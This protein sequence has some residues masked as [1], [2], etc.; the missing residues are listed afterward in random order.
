PPWTCSRSG[1]GGFGKLSSR[2]WPNTTSELGKPIH[3]KGAVM[4]TGTSPGWHS[5]G[6]EE[7]KRSW[8]WFLALGIVLVLLG[9]I[10]LSWSVLTTLVSV[11]VFGWLL[12]LGGV[13][14]VVH[15]FLRRRWGGF[16][17]ELFAG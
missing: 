8:V 1:R 3:Q 10:A 14:S 13:L 12:L 16:F 6:A 15:A 11:V 9:L 7:L 2:P 5:I 4:S 17:L